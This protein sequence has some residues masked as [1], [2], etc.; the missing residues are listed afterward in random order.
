MKA[1]TKS[2][3]IGWHFK[4]ARI[5]KGMTQLELSQFLGYG[6][7]QFVSNWER[8]KSRPPIQD[9]PAICKL[10][11]IDRKTITELLR[12]DAATRIEARIDAAYRSRK[13]GGKG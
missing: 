3:P 11:G 13:N 5:V 12:I 6:T 2:V 4:A 1:A 9:M 10:L 7:A 8:G